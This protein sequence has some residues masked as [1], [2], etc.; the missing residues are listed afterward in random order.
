MTFRNR[1][2]LRQVATAALAANALRPIPGMPLS[3][4]TFVSGWLT[5]ELA[6]QLLAATLADTAIH[7]ARRG[8]RT[9]GDVAAVA[10]AGLSAAGLAAVIA[11]GRGARSEVEAALTSALGSDY[12]SV[13]GRAE[14]VAGVP[15]QQLALPFRMRHADVVRV[16]NL[17]YAPGGR[18]FLIDVYHRRDVPVNAPILLQIHGGGWVIGSKDHQG[19]PL[20]LEMAS[21]GWVC[22]AV[23]Y[24][25]SPKAVWPAHLIAIKQAVAWL[26]DNASI[27]GG[28][29]GFVAV[30]GG[31]A[32][33]HLAA[34]LALTA[35]DPTLQPGFE[36]ADTS[37][38]A[39]APHYGVYDFAGE[40]GIKATR[41]R[42]ESGLMPMVLGKNARFPEDYEA[43]SPL[44]HLRPDAP[45]FFVVHGASDSFIP[46]A[47]AREFVRRLR[48]VS[49]NA[50]AYA[51]LRGA[52]HAFDIFPSIRSAAVARG[53]ADFLD[54]TRARQH[55]GEAASTEAAG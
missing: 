51:E 8:V 27:Y 31:S 52:Q 22:A 18:R 53:V 23:N 9:G 3:V 55:S 2:L 16:P 15:W 7:V 34:M 13:A 32:G 19:I 48:E 33:G 4:P 44:N 46:V 29:P 42:V 10:A 26:R 38:Q 11:T 54:W 43:A 24:P 17:E 49:E 47:E 41:Q 1:F 25:L 28:D 36:D 6:P 12:R 14:T 30:T 39:C 50:V 35:G 20:M 40:T 45:P 5:A 21:R 37:V